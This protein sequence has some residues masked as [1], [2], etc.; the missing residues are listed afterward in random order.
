MQSQ[1]LAPLGIALAAL[2]CLGCPSDD[3]LTDP[4]APMALGLTIQPAV[5]TIS[6]GDSVTVGSSAQLSLLAT[7]L[8]QPV[9]TPRA[10]WTTSNASVAI[11]DANGV[12]RAVTIGTV[13]ITARVNGTKATATVNVVHDVATLELSPTALTGAVGDSIVVTAAALDSRGSL[14]PGTVYSFSPM[15]STTA[16]VTRIGNQT[17]LVVLLEAGPVGIRV[18]AGGHTATAI[19]TATAR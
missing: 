16:S 18:T 3:T 12:V 4:N 13:T 9:A 11:V 19:G 17:A 2:V 8:G 6:T 10:S 5:V 15:D 7:S 14:V 1:R